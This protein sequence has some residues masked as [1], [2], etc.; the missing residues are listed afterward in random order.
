MNMRCASSSKKSR[1]VED[2]VCLYQERQPQSD[3]APLKGVFI[4][5]LL[6]R[7]YKLDGTL[8][9]ELPDDRLEQ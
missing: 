2:P 7:R 4:V 5:V 1:P 6:S 9:V 8:C 3:G